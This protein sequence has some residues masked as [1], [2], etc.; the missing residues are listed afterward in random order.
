[1]IEMSDPR[2]DKA[3]RNHIASLR[4]L[5]QAERTAGDL[6]AARAHA[7]QALRLS[8]EAAA[9]DQIA[10]CLH[11]LGKISVAEGA[12]QRAGSEFARALVAA[13]ASQSLLVAAFCCEELGQI[14][15]REGDEDFAEI[16]LAGAEDAFW[17]APD[18][19][20]ASTVE[21]LDEVDQLRQAS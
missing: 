4:D 2:L 9:E 14:G 10:S 16:M 18:L 17:R 1:M 20:A 7:L 8:E 15:L 11:L 21:K 5:A 6:E 12:D 19:S 13:C 3:R